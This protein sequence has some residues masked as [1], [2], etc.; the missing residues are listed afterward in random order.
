MPA[1]F[2]YHDLK[3]SM[4]IRNSHVGFNS[5]IVT[6]VPMLFTLL[7]S[8][9]NYTSFVYSSHSISM[10]LT[11]H[12]RAIHTQFSSQ[13][14]LHSHDILV[15]F[16]SHSQFPCD[17]CK[18][19]FHAGLPLFL[20]Y[21]RSIPKA[22]TLYLCSFH[23]PFLLKSYSIP[24]RIVTSYSIHASFPRRSHSVPRPFIL[25][26][27]IILTQF[28][29]HSHSL[30]IQFT[31]FSRTFHPWFTRHSHSFHLS[32]ILHSVSF[33]CCSLVVQT[34][35]TFYHI[36]II[37]TH[38]SYLRPCHVTQTLDTVH[39]VHM[40]FTRLTSFT[41]FIHMLFKRHSRDFEKLF[42]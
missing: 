22:F 5:M 23:S 39:A 15:L 19:H 26:F 21:T 9:S 25:D 8:H 41:S 32:F 40:K 12:S 37:V 7:H 14:T 3:N 38:N 20:C 13:F 11:L 30:P 29:F 17:V 35:Q 42:L 16:L 33:T 34:F 4:F 10:S 1:T 24:C 18:C 6:P 2:L 28:P 31:F 36:L 27:Q